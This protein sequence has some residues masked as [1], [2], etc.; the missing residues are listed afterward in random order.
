[1]PR[2]QTRTP[3]T[4]RTRSADSVCSTKSLGCIITRPPLLYAP[5]SDYVQ[6]LQYQATLIIRL[7]PPHQHLSLF[8][9]YL[10]SPVG[11]RMTMTFSTL[12]YASVSP[13]LRS[14]DTQPQRSLHTRRSSQR[15]RLRKPPAPEPHD[16][17]SLSTHKRKGHT[18]HDTHTQQTFCGTQVELSNIDFLAV[19]G[20]AARGKPS[21][22]R[23]E[24]H[25]THTHQPTPQKHVVSQLSLPG[26]HKNS[27]S[28]T[29]PPHTQETTHQPLLLHLL[30]ASPRHPPE[31]PHRLPAGPSP[32]LPPGLPTPTTRKAK[33][34]TRWEKR[35]A[36]LRFPWSPWPP[37]SPAGPARRAGAPRRSPCWPPERATQQ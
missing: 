1:V 21:R 29:P 24:E 25:P 11:W 8:S 19:R 14:S 27:H 5:P 34:R 18:L 26:T 7:G 32:L 10:T 35:P 9:S 2:P 13:C 3:R 12:P 33:A 16:G 4:S 31:A 20:A 30:A 23:R 36:R 17:R 6:L 22:D 15:S 28:D 37:G